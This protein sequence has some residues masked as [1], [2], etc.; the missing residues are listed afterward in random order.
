M[1]NEVLIQLLRELKRYDVVSRW[2]DHLE[3]QN[4]SVY[5]IVSEAN[6]E[7]DWV[8][9]EDLKAL[10]DHAIMSPDPNITDYYSLDEFNGKK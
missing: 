10:I 9:W 2:H 5:R 8:K 4:R 1:T 6:P 3:F 7:G